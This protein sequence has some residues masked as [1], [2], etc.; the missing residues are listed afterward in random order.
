MALEEFERDSMVYIFMNQAT[1]I[2][3]L[4]E[5]GG[6]PNGEQGRLTEIYNTGRISESVELREAKKEDEAL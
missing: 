5:K 4:L 3:K 2:E 6:E 1:S